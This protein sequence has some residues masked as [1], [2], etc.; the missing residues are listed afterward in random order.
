[1][2]VHGLNRFYFIDFQGGR[3]GPV[4]YDLASLLIDPYVGLPYSEQELLAEYCAEKISAPS[5]IDPAEFM[6]S[7]QYCRLAR[8]L[9]ILGAFGYLSKTKGKKWFEKY[10]PIAVQTLKTF[11]KEL[12]PEEMIEL[13]KQIDKIPDP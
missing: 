11:V 8:N 1:M 2:F 3:L 10:I 5:R 4:Q 6:K 7:Y 9:Q 13:K 12:D